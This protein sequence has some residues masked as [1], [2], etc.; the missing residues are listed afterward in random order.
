MI[1]KRLEPYRKGDLIEVVRK[2]DTMGHLVL[3]EMH[4]E[5]IKGKGIVLEFT[6]TSLYDG[7]WVRALFEGKEVYLDCKDIRLIHD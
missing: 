7:A 6:P 3:G 2:R 5:G 4:P 1:K